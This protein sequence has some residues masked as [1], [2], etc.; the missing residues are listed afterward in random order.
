MPLA[1]KGGPQLP[2][3]AAGSTA[4]WRGAPGAEVICEGALQG[5]HREGAS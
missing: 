5:E 1:S 4:G 3:R 2:P